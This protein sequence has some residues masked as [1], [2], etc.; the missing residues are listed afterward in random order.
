[1]KNQDA[2]I[3]KLSDQ[4][5]QTKKIVLATS[6]YARNYTTPEEIIFIKSLL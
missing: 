3:S 1:M 4:F 2:D 5:E 6:F